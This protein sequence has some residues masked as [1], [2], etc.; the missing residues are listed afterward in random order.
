MIK[1]KFNPKNYDLKIT[2]HA[3][4]GKKGEDIVCSA[5]STLFY[6][7]GEALYESRNML[8]GKLTFVNDNGKGHIWC[9]PKPEYE[10]NIARTYWTIMVGFDLVA[11]NYEKNVKFE[12]LGGK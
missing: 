7:L 2:G 11:K 8:D 6:T 9:K 10:G 3:D 5:I 1:I 12:I 4:H